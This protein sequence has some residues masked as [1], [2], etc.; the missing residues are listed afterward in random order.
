MHR[1]MCVCLS[2]TFNNM[3]NAQSVTNFDALLRMVWLPPVVI[4]FLPK[5]SI[6]DF[7][8]IFSVQEL[9]VAIVPVIVVAAKRS[10]ATQTYSV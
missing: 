1:R 8:P 2:N 7:S 4:A 9:P 10:E 6:S 3:A 5:M